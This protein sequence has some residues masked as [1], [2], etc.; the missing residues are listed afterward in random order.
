MMDL[1]VWIENS[2]LGTWV[3]ESVSLWA[4]PGMIAFHTIGLGF[5]VGTSFAISLRLLG[6]AESLPLSAL[7]KFYPAMYAGFWVNF[8]S[9]V[10]LTTV[11]ASKMVPNP[12]FIVKMASIVGAVLCMRLIKMKVLD[13]AAVIQSGAVPRQGTVLAVASIACWVVAIVFGRAIAYELLLAETFGLG[14]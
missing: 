2:M 9:G 14:G 7:E 3:R 12:L 6:A 10:A 13:D 1:L 5:V 8:L 4:Y 11:S